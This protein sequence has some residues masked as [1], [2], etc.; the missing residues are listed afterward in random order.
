[1]A[2]GALDR[3]IASMVLLAE[4]PAV[5]AR[6]RVAAGQVIRSLLKNRPPRKRRSAA[7]AKILKE[8]GGKPS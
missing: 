7:V 5:A 8:M 3:T 2:K 4:D 1:M 6:E